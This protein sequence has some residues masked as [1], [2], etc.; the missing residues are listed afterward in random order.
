M[1]SPS[2]TPDDQI[3]SMK[4]IFHFRLKNGDSA[5]LDVANNQLIINASDSE[6]RSSTLAYA[7]SRLLQLL[8]IEPG[9]IRSRNE[10]MEFA[11]E[12][13]VV[14]AGSLNQAIF[15]LRNL[16]NDGRDHELLQTVPRRGYRFNVGY[17]D[18]STSER[19][20]P[21]FPQEAGVTSF[22]RD[23][24]S[25]NVTPDAKPNLVINQRALLIPAYALMLGVFAYLAA[26]RTDLADH[27]DSDL[28]IE[29]VGNELATYHF[30]GL[31]TEENAHNIE[32][33]KTVLDYK[34]TDIRGDVW[35]NKSNRMYDLSCVTPN[36]RTG[37]VLF[38]ETNKTADLQL[39]MVKKCL[40]GDGDQ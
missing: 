30:V 32:A 40:K 8:L 35:I 11:W 13:R 19:P 28:V 1:D 26:T 34:G 10:I 39:L 7:E 18:A 9:A 24:D 2:T 27:L 4:E 20:E 3:P 25:S 17:V 5:T 14:T 21:H 36:G 12:K 29:T 31:N 37:N 23:L 16:I 22:S 33:F 38:S 15:T 6:P